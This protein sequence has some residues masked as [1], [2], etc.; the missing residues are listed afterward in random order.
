MRTQHK[1]PART[2]KRH[3]QPGSSPG[4]LVYTGEKQQDTV[5]LQLI[6]F[7][8]DAIH[9]STETDIRALLGKIDATQVNWINVSGLHDTAVIESLGSHFTI[10]PLVLEDILHTEH[11]PKLEEH[12]NYLFLT[13]KILTYSE[14]RNTIEREHISMVLGDC[15][16]ITFQEKNSGV[17]DVIRDTLNSGTGRL[18]KRKADYLFYRLLDTIVDHYWCHSRHD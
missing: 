1:R 3:K 14:E 6:Q 15:Y 16:L 18:R 17:F 10:D 9:A 2:E 4:S 11:M 5:S 12:D 13:L 8:E 7:T